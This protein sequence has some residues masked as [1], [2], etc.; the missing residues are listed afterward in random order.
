MFE[1]REYLK[2]NT[3]YIPL[4]DYSYK[5]FNASVEVD[6]VVKV[7][8]VLGYKYQGKEKLPV[9]STVS[10]T[11]KSIVAKL[12]VHGKIVDHYE[13]ENDQKDTKEDTSKLKD[14]AYT[15]IRK[16]L[17]DYGVKK[18]SLESI[19]SE[20]DFT[21]QVDKIVLDFTSVV[22][23][24]YDWDYPM[25]ES[26]LNDILDGVELIKSA[27]KC[28]NV[29]IFFDKKVKNIVKDVKEARVVNP[30][31]FTP[32]FKEITKTKKELSK[33]VLDAGVMYLDCHVPL[34]VLDSINGVYPTVQ[35][36]FVTGD[37][38]TT[39]S[40]VIAKIGMNIS[41]VLDE[42]VIQDDLD[43]VCHL[44]SYLTG[45]S[46]VSDDFV[47]SGMLRSVDVSYAKTIEEDV[48]IRCGKCNDVCPSNILPQN[49]MDAELREL[50]E[51][52]VELKSYQ[53]IEC[54]LCSMHCPSD[55]NVLE[56]VRRSKRRVE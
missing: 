14:P 1:K 30:N 19:Y 53:C 39:P 9:L 31:K 49:I 27:A 56:W 11:V 16:R 28:D 51:R 25:L 2:P 44:G 46:V 43:K 37:A 50:N 26:K 52:I 23:F 36:F 20:L 45:H 48:C 13:I 29:V 33:T 10:G 24:K 35:G 40:L 6:D 47:V 54:G 8:T 21:K 38:V 18:V 15:L 7:G 34:R 22:T 3:V 5:L 4:T 12:D 32:I 17:L 41:E 42:L 55:I